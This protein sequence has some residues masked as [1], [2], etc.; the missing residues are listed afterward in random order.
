MGIVPGMS[1]SFSPAPVLKSNRLAPDLHLVVVDGNASGLADQYTRPGQYAMVRVDEHKAV[2]LAFAAAPGIAGELE[3]F[4]RLQSPLTE[5]LANLK[6]GEAL[7]M[8]PPSGPGFP[9]EEAREKHVI[10]MGIGTGIAPIRALVQY[11]V[12]GPLLTH[13]LTLYYG[14]RTKEQVCFE[15]DLEH[16]ANSGVDVHLALSQPEDEDNKAWVHHL[17]PE[18]L[19]A[20]EDTT[21]FL[22]G[23]RDM[24]RDARAVLEELGIF[25]EQIHRNY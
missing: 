10:F 19:M 25:D 21:V 7:E 17:L 18:K 4:I 2:P 16:W 12:D 6:E 11:L 23:H 5:A 22:C 9:L 8:S 20:P 1:L 13:T 3:F 24:E 15:S 14:V